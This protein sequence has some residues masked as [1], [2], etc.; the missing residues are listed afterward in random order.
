[1]QLIEVEVFMYMFTV[2]TFNSKTLFVCVKGRVCL[3]V[4]IPVYFNIFRSIF[5]V[6]FCLL[7]KKLI[8]GSKIIRQSMRKLPCAV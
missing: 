6:L 8:L 2:F 1:M 4:A 7:I 3:K 5:G